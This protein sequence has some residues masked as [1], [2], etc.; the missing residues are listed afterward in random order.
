MKCNNCFS[1]TD[2]PPDLI[3]KTGEIGKFLY[4]PICNHIYLLLDVDEHQDTSRRFEDD[5]DI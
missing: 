4:C 5:D 3:E 2:S 1:A